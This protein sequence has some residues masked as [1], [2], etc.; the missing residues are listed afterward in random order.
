MR[1]SHIF[2]RLPRGAAFAVLGVALTTLALSLSQCQMVEERL[3][4][5]S[6][7]STKPDLCVTNCTTTYNGFIR[8]ESTTH[9]ANVKN[10]ASDS[11]CLALEGMRHDAEVDRIQIAR[12]A[13]LAE[14]RHQ[15]SGGGGR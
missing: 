5:V 1:H 7:N 8:V 6:L 13:C 3:T 11:L 10:C 14:C 15:G 2:G 12:Y 9:V 4:G